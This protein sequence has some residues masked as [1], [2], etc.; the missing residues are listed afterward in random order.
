LDQHQY[1]LRARVGLATH[2]CLA[3][4]LMSL[5]PLLLSVFFIENIFPD[6]PN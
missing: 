5:R 2:W 3:S 4:S 6:Y 1:P